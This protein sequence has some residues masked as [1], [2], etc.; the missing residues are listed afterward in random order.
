MLKILIIDDELTLRETVAEFCALVG[1]EV[2]QAVDGFDGLEKIQLESPDL[3]LCDVMMP[4]MDGLIF[5]KKHFFS[6]HAHI[7]VVL[8]TA[9]IEHEDE[10]NSFKLGVKACIK[11]PF[12]FSDLHQI[13]LNNVIKI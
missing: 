7:P 10:L 6:N 11:K 3:I 12:N 2:V 13:I 4:N 1:Y 5:I 8:M 9:K